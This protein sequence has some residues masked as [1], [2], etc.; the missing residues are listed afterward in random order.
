VGIE[1]P[2]LGL[3]TFTLIAAMIVSSI[4]LLGIV[5]MNVQDYMLKTPVTEGYARCFTESISG[6]VYRYQVQVVVANSGGSDLSIKRLYVSTD[7]GMV[8]VPVTSPSFTTTLPVGST[9]VS[10]SVRLAG[11]TGLDLLRGQRGYVHVNLT[12]TTQL[13]TEGRVYTLYIYLTTIGL[14]GFTVQ[15]ARFKVGEIE[16]CIPI[17][18]PPPPPPFPPSPTPFTWQLREYDPYTGTW[19]DIRFTITTGNALRMDSESTGPASVGM[20]LCF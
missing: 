13:Y 18:L 17:T 12:S 4:V 8:E 11:F 6:G 19:P 20:G 9:S 14:D 1:H 15:E 5:G 16:S 2:I 7:H 3:M 10:L